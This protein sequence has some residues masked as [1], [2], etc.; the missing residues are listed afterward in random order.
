MGIASITHGDKVFRFRTDPNSIRWTY[1]VNT[2]VDETYGGRVIQILSVKVENLTVTADCGMGGWP[3]MM[4]VATQFRD[5]LVNQR[6]GAPAVFSY[7]PRGYKLGCYAT[8]MPFKDAWD[9][10]AREFTMTFKVQEDISGL[11][12]SSSMS[13]ELARLKEGIGFERNGYNYN[14]GDATKNEGGT[15]PADKP[16]DPNILNNLGA[17]PI[18]TGTGGI[19]ELLTGGLK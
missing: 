5:L 19:G 16:T 15:Q 7:A 4:E 2:K 13:A 14:G 17:G 8:A 1:T 10:V 3:Y 18:N 9:A 6:G 12:T 11:V